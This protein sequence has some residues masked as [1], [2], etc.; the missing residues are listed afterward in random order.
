MEK[1]TAEQI[2]AIAENFL[3]NSEWVDIHQRNDTTFGFRIGYNVCQDE[4]LTSAPSSKSIGLEWVRVDFK[5]KNGKTVFIEV[6][7]ID[8]IRNSEDWLY[9]K[10]DKSVPCSCNINESTPHCECGG[11]FEDFEL[12]YTSSHTPVKDESPQQP[13][14]EKEEWVS[15]EE[16]IPP[17]GQVVSGM[18]LEDKWECNVYWNG[19]WWFNEGYDI[20]DSTP[21]YPTHWKPITSPLPTESYFL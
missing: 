4:L 1:K 14:S 6:R 16:E 21:C 9:E 3:K 12:C 18:H 2:K 15:T 17:I 7:L 8:L 11:S 5:H 19:W 10:L 13:V 20:E